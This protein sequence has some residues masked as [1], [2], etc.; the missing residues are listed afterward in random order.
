MFFTWAKYGC[1]DAN[2]IFKGDDDTLINPFALQDFLTSE[3]RPD[4]VIYGCLLVVQ[5]VQKKVDKIFHIY[6]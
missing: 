3:N 1:D 2:Y 6:K 5:P 4:P